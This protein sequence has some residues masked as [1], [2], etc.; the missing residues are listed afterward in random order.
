[1]H[2]RPCAR[3]RSLSLSIPHAPGHSHAR[4]THA[5]RGGRG[6]R[7]CVCMCVREADIEREIHTLRMCGAGSADALKVDVSS[8]RSSPDSVSL[9]LSLTHMLSLSWSLSRSISSPHTHQSLQLSCVCSP[10]LTHTYHVSHTPPQSLPPSRPPP[11]SLLLHSSPFLS[12]S[13]SL[14]GVGDRGVCRR[15]GH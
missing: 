13:L 4:R 3:A 5:E 2:A 1:M 14:A 10:H 8:L 12:L 11:T 7:E 6:G 9:S 15:K